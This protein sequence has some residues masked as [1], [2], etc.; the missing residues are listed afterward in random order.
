[1]FSSL[2]K[3]SARN[4]QNFELPEKSG[5][6]TQGTPWT[7]L[8]TLLFVNITIEC[9]GVTVKISSSKSLSVSGNNC[10]KVHSTGDRKGV[11][12]D[13]KIQQFYY[14]KP[15]VPL[16]VKMLRKRVSLSR[17]LLSL[18]SGGRKIK[19]MN[20]MSEDWLCV[21]QKLWGDKIQ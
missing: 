15:I 9:V 20:L 6:G 12:M 10:V 4:F 1:M 11:A 16:L 21:M 2:Y 5:P 13:P 17:V 3:Y 8:S 19:E 18:T 7:P 14:T